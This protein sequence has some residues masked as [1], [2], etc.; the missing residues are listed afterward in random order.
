[1]RN[2]NIHFLEIPFESRLDYL[3]ETYGKLEMSELKSATE[4]I[5]KKLGGLET[6]TALAFLEENNILS[7]PGYSIA[8]VPQKKGFQIVAIYPGKKTRMEIDEEGNE[9]TRIKPQGVDTSFLV[10]TL[11]A[12]IQELKTIVDTQAAEI[13]ELKTKVGN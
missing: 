1:M 7:D 12:A 13:A 4:R 8:I 6:K 10:A 5:Q 11:T 9:Q 2:S 3:V